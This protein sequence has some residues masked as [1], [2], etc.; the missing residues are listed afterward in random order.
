MYQWFRDCGVKQKLSIGYALVLLLTLLIALT[1]WV[2]TNT[3]I[4]RSGNLVAADALRLAFSELRQTRQ[5]YVHS[6]SDELHAQL[7]NDLRFFFDAGEALDKRLKDPAD[8]AV[9]QLGANATLA[10]RESVPLLHQQVQEQT[11]LRKG[12]I[13]Q[14]AAVDDGI[15][16][17]A[18]QLR[19]ARED[20]DRYTEQLEALVDL[21]TYT[22][23]MRSAVNRYWASA[24]DSTLE[25]AHNS[26]KSVHAH[27]QSLNRTLP[28][29]LQL[30][31]SAPAIEGALASYDKTRRAILA[32]MDDMLENGKVAGAQTDT[33]HQSQLSKI[34]SESAFYRNL[35]IIAT[36]LALGLGLGAAALITRQIMHPLRET[37]TAAERVSQGDL[38]VDLVINRHDEL[39][40]L[41]RSMQHMIAN[42]REL[43]GN[44]HHGAIQ[45]ASASEQLSAVTEQTSAGVNLQKDETEQVATAINEMSAT[46]QDVARNAEQASNAATEADQQAR[47]GEQVVRS[48]LAQMDRLA[49]EVRVSNE[50]VSQV[51]LDSEKIGT[52]LD[53]IKAVAEQTNLLAL[54]AAI[55]AA[56]AGDAGRGFAVVA[57]EV[58]S[59]A[60]RTQKSTEEIEGL[61][62]QLQQGSYIAAERMDSSHSMTETTLQLTQDAGNRLSEI[63]NAVTAIQTMNQQIAAAAE[64]QN[65]V[66]DEI[67]RSVVKVRDISEQSASASEETAASSVEL[68][69]LSYELQAQVARFKL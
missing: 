1:G 23:R 43:I 8:K 52:V 61:I 41:Q 42:L 62:T 25:G 11:Q 14:M 53:V 12:L 4:A 38:T 27:T 58:R 7:T 68:A 19:F 5:Q 16:K 47:G 57:D 63:V 13:E 17:L 48:A 35:L 45:I 36:V 50:A 59:L 66:A 40:L 69:R 10:Y 65:A 39:G 54:N 34:E 3:I 60:L 55:E 32:L 24:N 64:Q 26:I 67:N 30:I 2:S 44:I 28:N 21:L 46:V 56:R 37:L 20:N 51:R 33:L 31:E 18:Q 49:A 29:N 22:Q 6:P 9:T 15:S